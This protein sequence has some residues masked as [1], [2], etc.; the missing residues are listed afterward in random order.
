[1]NLKEIPNSILYTSLY[2]VSNGYVWPLLGMKKYENSSSP[3]LY[4]Q[5][6]LDLLKNILNPNFEKVM[7]DK[8][9][10][11]YNELN[12]KKIECEEKYKISGKD[13]SELIPYIKKE[14]FVKNQVSKYQ[15]LKLIKFN[16]E[17]F[18]Q[19]LMEL[20]KEKGFPFVYSIYVNSSRSY[21]NLFIN[22]GQVYLIPAS[23]KNNYQL[24]YSHLHAKKMI[25]LRKSFEN[26]ET[27]SDSN[28]DEKE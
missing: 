9:N 8:I 10:E 16:F 6:M 2:C 1:M 11:L 4:K 18:T 5:K 14:Y 13:R 23:S 25:N 17:K 12:D 24:I 26:Q 3:L 22:K 19:H 28:N 7:D 27:S 21:N 20:Y 15:D